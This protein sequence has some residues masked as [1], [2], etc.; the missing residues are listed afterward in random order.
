MKTMK[1]WTAHFFIG[2]AVL[3]A[4]GT[5]RVTAADVTMP[6]KYNYGGG[7]LLI[8]GEMLFNSAGYAGSCPNNH[9]DPDGNTYAHGHLPHSFPFYH[10]P[11]GSGSGIWVTE[12]HSD[13][14]WDAHY[15]DGY[16]RASSSTFVKN[17]FAHAAVAPVSGGPVVMW[18][19]GYNQFTT[20]SS[21][22]E[23]TTKTKS[24]LP[25]GDHAVAFSTGPSGLESVP[26]IVTSTSEK[27][28][29]SGVYTREWTFN[30]ENV[31]KRK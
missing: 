27:N 24:Y 4:A 17:C 10:E 20:A 26:C 7:G 31:R 30:P 28:A 18:N 25:S 12:A 5:W 21:V 3:L 19:A 29:S 13:M 23:N 1:N 16:T 2:F 11:F 22:C 8:E 14:A 15:G 9:L 6:F